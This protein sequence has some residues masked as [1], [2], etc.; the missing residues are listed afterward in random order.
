MRSAR[1][2]SSVTRTMFGCVAAAERV[3]SKIQLE[4]SKAR[5]KERQNMTAS[6][7]A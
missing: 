2:D 4:I 6:V 7:I 1:V 5:K 3:V